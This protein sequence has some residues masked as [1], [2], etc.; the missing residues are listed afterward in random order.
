M[1]SRFASALELVSVYRRS[2]SYHWARRGQLTRGG[3]T[4]WEAEF[5][6][7]ALAVEEKPVSPTLRLTAGVLVA[8]VGTAVAWATFGRS[9]IVA[10]AEGKVIPSGRS[11]VI[12]SVDTATV[13]S[14]HVT[15]GQH[16]R[17]GDVLIELDGTPFEADRDKAK[18]DERKA[19][20]QMACAR[21]M[22]AALDGRQRPR[23]GPVEGLSPEEL[24]EG[25]THL[26]GEYDDFVAKL[27]RADT[28][29]QYYAAALPLA[30]QRE[31][32]YSS[33]LQNR[34][35]STDAWLEK[36]QARIDLQGRLADAQSARNSLVA[37]TR[38]DSLDALAEASKAADGSREDA[39]HAGAHAGWLTLRAPEDGTV[40]QLSVH[41]LG[42]VVEAAQPLMVIVPSASRVEVEA[43]ISNKDIG[44]V[45]VGQRA[46]VK[47][48][49]F[50]YTK[51]GAVPGEVSFV[52]PD[53]IEGKD[54][55]LF[56]S[57]RI[58][59]DRRSITVEKRDVD[60][61][62][63]MSVMADIKTGRRRIVEYVLSPLVRHG[64]ESLRE[65]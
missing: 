24:R 52:S 16:V 39:I 9:D 34:D 60:L 10:T 13:R 61:S 49:A 50:E 17:A 3:L 6:P 19:R 23:L 29:V 21:A 11:K 4:A 1:S 14:I 65:R 59:L 44:F 12:A 43:S 55:E 46:A 56:Y 38:R 37:V 7:P 64:S 20:L 5:S 28:N 35:V 41:T 45:Q 42:G 22:L 36:K 32:I 63:G 25:Q 40:Q 30:A 51:Y 2:L 48:A 8:L 26:D 53:A 57:I 31:S 27:A 18:A 62:P 15:E 47:V 54:H 33:L 58:L